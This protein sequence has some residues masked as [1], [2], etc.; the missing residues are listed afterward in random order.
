MRTGKKAGQGRWEIDPV[1]Q[2]MVADAARRYLAG[3]SMRK[4]AAGYGQNSSHLHRTIT[5]RCGPVWVQRVRCKELG[6]DKTIETQ[7]P[8]LLDEETIKAVRERARANSTYAHGHIRHKYLLSRVVFCKSCGRAMTG[9]G[10]KR[11]AYRYYRH[12]AEKTSHCP[13]SAVRAADIEETVLHLLFETFGNP[14]AVRRA[15]EEATPDAGKLNEDRK[16]LKLAEAELSKVVAAKGRIVDAIA[17]GT[18]AA[19]D[20]RGKLDQLKEQEAALTERVER[21]RLTIGDTPTAEQVEQAADSV[22]GA[23]KEWSRPWCKIDR[24]NTS[25]ERMPFE[26]RRRLCQLVFG[27]KDAQGRRLGV[28]VARDGDG[29]RYRIRGHFIKEWGRLFPAVGLR[30][31]DYTGEPMRQQE[32]LDSTKLRPYQ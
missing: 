21:L 5:R 31:E 30:D 12:L 27:G 11:P 7:V 14:A 22:A 13:R 19:S 28:Y 3:E 18:L 2:A 1:K 25:I 8:P 23:F 6:I 32:L 17:E 20:A 24:A 10:G 26:E 4:I 15:I 29:W 16:S 9:C